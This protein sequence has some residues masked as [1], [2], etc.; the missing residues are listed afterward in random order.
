MDD[1]RHDIKHL[2]EII[3]TDVRKTGARLR[4]Q[5]VE[6]LIIDEI[7]MISAK[8]FDTLE[9]VCRVIRGREVCISDK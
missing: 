4:I 8:T 6:T 5:E 1:G 2:I 3:Q 9:T 7:S